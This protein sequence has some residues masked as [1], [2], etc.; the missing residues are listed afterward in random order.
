[1]A[2]HP[3]A[4]GLAARLGALPHTNNRGERG[5]VHIPGFLTTTGTSPEML[6]QNGTLGLAIA[7]ATIE[8]LGENGWRVIADDELEAHARELAAEKAPDTD[9][10]SVKCNR[11]LGVVFNLNIAAGDPVID[12]RMIGLAV[13]AHQAVCE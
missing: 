11:C 13:D 5:L 10:R 1:M 7:E 8:A 2:E 6:E 12:I 3:A 9:A 4:P